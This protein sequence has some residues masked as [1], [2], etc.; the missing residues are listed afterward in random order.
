MIYLLHPFSR[1]RIRASTFTILSSVFSLRRRTRVQVVPCILSQYQY[2]H[3]RKKKHV[4]HLPEPNVLHRAPYPVYQDELI[5]SAVLQTLYKGVSSLKQTL[6][7]ED[8]CCFPRTPQ[9]LG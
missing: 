7:D 6:E 3:T 8:V 2:A 9:S 1:P 4:I 5:N